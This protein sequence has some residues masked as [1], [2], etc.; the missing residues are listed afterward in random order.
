MSV[1]LFAA[2]PFVVGGAV[3]LDEDAAHH[4]RVRRVVSGE[5]VSLHDGN[6]TVASGQLT[7]LTK[8]RAVVRVDGLTQVRRLPAVHLLAPIGDRDRMLWLVEKATEL[9]VTSWQAVRWRRSLSV[10]PRGDGDGFRAKVRAR[11]RGALEQSGGAWLPEVL[12]ELSPAEAAAAAPAEGE[13]YLLTAGA[14]G[15]LRGAVEAP[16]TIVLGPEGGIADD[17]AALFTGAGFRAVSVGPNVMRFETAGVAALV[18]ARAALDGNPG[19]S[20]A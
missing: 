19:G 12:P 3:T 10:G 14:P 2:G 11:M 7:D 20:D 13:R 16:V 6:G 9:G 8:S 5:L 15:M 17:E 18:L 1:R 4:L